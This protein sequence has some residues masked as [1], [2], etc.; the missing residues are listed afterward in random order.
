MPFDTQTDIAPTISSNAQSQAAADPST[1]STVGAAF[2]QNNMVGSFLASDAAWTRMRGGFDDI[3]RDYNVFDDIKGYENHMGRFENVF[4]AR[5]AAAVKADIDRETQDKKILEASGWTGTVANVGASVIDLPSLIP[6]GA[7]VGNGGKVGYSVVKSAVAGAASA[8]A[9]TALQEAGLQ[10]TQ[11]TRPLS[12]SATAV[13][14]SVLLGALLGGGIATVMNRG[15]YSAASKA[16]QDA[17]HPNFDAETDALHADLTAMSRHGQ[18]VGAAATPR[19]PI[20]NFD[21]AG[22]AAS[23]TAKATAKLNPLLRTIQS[24]SQTVR[25]VA[26]QM[27]ENPVYLKRNLQ[28]LGDAAA[29]TSMHEWTRGAVSSAVED[30]NSAYTSLRKRGLAM[31]RDDFNDLVGEAMRRGDQSDIPEVAQAAQSARAKVFDPLKDRAIKAGL[32]P[33]DVTPDTAQSYFSRM[34]SRPKIEADEAGFKKILRDYFDGQVNAAAERE[35][36]HTDQVLNSLASVRDAI[37]NGI[38]E[39]AAGLAGIKNA[40][41]QHLPGKALR[42]SRPA[43]IRSPA[44]PRRR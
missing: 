17:T 30:F 38:S 9:A 22:T 41:A 32:L 3:D 14:G 44:G 19:E 31:T 7:L 27:L 43:S 28:G 6:V 40:V 5:A 39:R 36:S 2:R 33:E 12:Q 10:A 42:H 18:S 4:N 24:P 35:A 15:E 8:G 29:E 20:T 13:G 26:A 11:E 16:L 23:A 21:V 34:W 25:E 37:T 1:L